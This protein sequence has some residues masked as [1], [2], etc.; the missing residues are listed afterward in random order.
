VRIRF[1]VDNPLDR[2]QKIKK[3]FGF[4][5]ST[6]QLFKSLMEK[7]SDGRMVILPVE[8][9]AEYDDGT[10]ECV[11]VFVSTLSGK[12]NQHINVL[13]HKIKP[14]M[15]VEENKEIKNERKGF[16]SRI[17]GW[18][19]KIKHSIICGGANTIASPFN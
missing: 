17:N 18:Y 7:A 6:N 3:T 5:S 8:I 13:P 10:T 1:S 16:R 19:H 12:Q 14:N 9:A 11:T 4:S 2:T 15:V